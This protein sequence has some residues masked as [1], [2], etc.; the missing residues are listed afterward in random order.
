MDEIKT[1]KYKVVNNN[2]YNKG[3]YVIT[4]RKATKQDKES[5]MLEYLSEEWN[6]AMDMCENNGINSPVDIWK[7]NEYSDKEMIY[8]YF[9]EVFEHCKELKITKKEG[10]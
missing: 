6:L 9:E 3:E 8:M 5:T 1:R 7:N 2:I 10:K 4:F